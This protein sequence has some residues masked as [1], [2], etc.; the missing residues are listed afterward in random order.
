MELI[1]QDSMVGC[2]ICSA[3]MV[4]DCTVKEV[5]EYLGH[6]GTTMIVPELGDPDGLAAFHIQ[7]IVDFA[8][9]R[10]WAVTSIEAR[11]MTLYRNGQAIEVATA[12]DRFYDHLATSR[13]I[14]AIEGKRGGHAVALVGGM[15]YD[16]KGKV[17]PLD[18]IMDHDCKGLI[19]FFRF[20]QI[21]STT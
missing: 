15:V 8:L 13:G 21:K 20:D 17:Y 11:P 3:A 18:E 12:E 4:L 19:Q 7:E 6:D 9:D 1:R 10:G 14:L 2:L 5:E 16:P